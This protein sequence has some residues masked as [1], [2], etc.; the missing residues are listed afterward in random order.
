MKPTKHPTPERNRAPAIWQRSR[1]RDAAFFD[2][3]ELTAM[4]QAIDQIMEEMVKGFETKRSVV[5]HIVFM[6]ASETS[7]FHTE[8]LVKMARE[9]MSNAVEQ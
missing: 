8:L 2:N 3:V 9:R 5:A 1:H 7:E 4:R 6:I